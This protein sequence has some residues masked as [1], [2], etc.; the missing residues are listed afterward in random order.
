MKLTLNQ[1][2]FDIDPQKDVFDPRV[3]QTPLGDEIKKFQVFY[4]N[5]RSEEGTF[6]QGIGADKILKIPNIVGFQ[7]FNNA[8]MFPRPDKTASLMMKVKVLTAVGARG[9]A[10]LESTISDLVGKTEIKI[11]ISKYEWL[12]PSASFAVWAEVEYAY[13]ELSNAARGLRFFF[14]IPHS[15]TLKCDVTYLCKPSGVAEGLEAGKSVEHHYLGPVGGEKQDGTELRKA[16]LRARIRDLEKLLMISMI[17][18]LHL[19]A[20]LEQARAELK[21]LSG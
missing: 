9:V 18:P 10:K 20:E 1:I 6:A 11:D 16:F 14:G 3:E 17:R 8:G 21:K 13:F 19:V 2:E 7:E 4:W 12:K 15:V 5:C